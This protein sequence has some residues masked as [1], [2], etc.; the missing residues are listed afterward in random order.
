MSIDASPNLV[1]MIKA[2]RKAMRGVRRDFNEI[3]KL[4][5]S[6]KGPGDFV[7]R[8]DIN[9]ERTLVEALQ[10]AHPNYSFLVEESGEIKG[11]GIKGEQYRWIIDPIDGTTNFM[12]GNPNFCVSVALEERLGGKSQII[13]AMV[14]APILG[15]TFYAAKG[16]GAYM[17]NR[18]GRK[19]RL[20][21]AER[22]QPQDALIATGRIIRG[23]EP[24]DRM[25]RELSQATHGVRSSGSAALDLAFTAAG[26]FDAFV[27]YHLQ[28]WDIAAGILLM[29]EAGGL[30]TDCDN[31][32]E[33][34]KK[35]HIVATNE[36]LHA[37]LL[38]SLRA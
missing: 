29:K 36:R 22:T 10:E 25:I 17:E 32:D 11:E 18:E 13:A 12:H 35:Q 3:E 1:V 15:E 28:P 2:I 31:G 21:I 4:Q 30:V 38:K 33:M 37:K 24:Q 34:L 9:A 19:E 14:E 20:R 23:E 26:R 16:K 6:Q 27:D 5:V 7:T 8:S